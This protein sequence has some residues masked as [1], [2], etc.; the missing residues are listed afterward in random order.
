MKT[1]LLKTNV[2]AALLAIGLSACAGR[3]A[4]LC[5]PAPRA[6]AAAIV[7]NGGSV[8]DVATDLG[9]SN[10]DAR[11]VVRSTAHQLVVW[12]SATR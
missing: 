7:L 9:L 8:D 5:S 10:R 12:V 2:I 1:N 3:A 4:P 11:R 6:R